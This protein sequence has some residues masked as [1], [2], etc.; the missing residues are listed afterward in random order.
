MVG[1]YLLYA[2]L[3]S[4]RIPS[5]TSQLTSMIIPSYSFALF[6]PTIIAGLGF[7]SSN[8]QLLSVPPN[9]CGGIFTI[10]FGIYSDRW[11]AR[12]AFVLLGSVTAL[13]GYVVLFATE[14]PGAGY[15]GATI[16]ACGLYPSLPCILAWASGNGGGDVKRAV[17]VAMVIGVA[18]LGGY[19]TSKIYGG[20]SDEHVGV[21]LHLPSSIGLK[22]V[23]GITL[24]MPRT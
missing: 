2:G 22:T 12:G 18:N 14:T 24:D 10:L 7:S 9:V 6:L 8:A 16:A 13:V 21:G 3:F 11:H 17:V 15:T 20:Y 4:F 19:G 23:L 1:M 5:M